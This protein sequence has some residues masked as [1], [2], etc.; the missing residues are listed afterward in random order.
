MRRASAL[1]VAVAVGLQEALRLVEVVHRRV[2]EGEAQDLLAR[3]NVA[4]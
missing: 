1:G 2:A 4:G 3:S